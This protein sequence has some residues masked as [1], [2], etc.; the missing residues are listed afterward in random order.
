MSWKLIRT[1]IRIYSNQNLA[2]NDYPNIFVSK[3]LTRTNIRIYLYPK[4]DTNEYPNKYSDQK[5]SNIRIYSSHSGSG[6]LPR[7]SACAQG[8]RR[9][10]CSG[11]FLFSNRNFLIERWPT[12]CFDIGRVF[13]AGRNDMYN[14][15]NTLSFLSS[16][17]MVSEYFYKLCWS[18]TNPQ[19]S[20]F[21]SQNMIFNLL[22][23]L[24]FQ[25]SSM[26]HFVHN[27]FSIPYCRKGSYGPYGLFW[28][29]AKTTRH[30]VKLYKK[31]E[32]GKTKCFW[33]LW[34]LI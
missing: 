1:N 27:S 28:F 26:T 11:W 4:N 15:T 14:V 22:T 9:V 25:F 10:A 18:W 6:W 5:Y 2:T 3:K 23:P 20:N 17:R 16:L 24:M 30:N 21:G 34:K 33:L 29:S 7:G 32:W 31:R 19:K 8:G 12:F 13:T